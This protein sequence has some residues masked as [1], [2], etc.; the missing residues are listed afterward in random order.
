MDVEELSQIA[1]DCGLRV[2]KG[3]GPGL[4]ES[5]Y[6][7]VLAELLVRRGLFVERQ[8]LIPIRFE[9]LEIDAG[10]RA[11][12]LIE[13]KLLIE[14]KA[15]EKTAPVHGKQVLTY[16]RFLDLPVGLLMNFGADT[17]REGLRRIVNNH[18]NT[19]RSSLRVNQ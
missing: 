4:L 3:L 7:A 17:F 18:Q 16:L 9:N 15:I 12:L 10:F 13:G 6:E 2:H 14:L 5:A 19:A 11:D 1:V 8:K